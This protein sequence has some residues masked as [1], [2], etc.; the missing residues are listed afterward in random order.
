MPVSY[1]FG[2]L[3]DYEKFSSK[4]FLSFTTCFLKYCL[5]KIYFSDR[6]IR[7]MHCLSMDP[8]PPRNWEHPKHFLDHP[9]KKVPK[10]THLL[11]KKF[12]R[13]SLSKINSK[14]FLKN[15][16]K[17]CPFFCHFW[18]TQKKRVPFFVTFEKRKKGTPLFFVSFIFF[19]F[20]FIEFLEAFSEADACFLYLW[21][22]CSPRKILLQKI[23]NLQ[24]IL[25][26]WF[27]R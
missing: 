9:K 15:S 6:E 11:Q 20:L 3:A 8:T 14:K 12:F 1:I 24:D 4:K 17:E 26:G 21:I 18:K 10:W 27:S 2:S 7:N 5:G 25:F 23:S 16:K 19:I 13:R 22:T